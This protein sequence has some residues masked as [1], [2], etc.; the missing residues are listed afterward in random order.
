VQLFKPSSLD[1]IFRFARGNNHLS[2]KDSCEIYLAF[3][4]SIL[5]SPS[6]FI[7]QRNTLVIFQLKSDL[8]NE[9]F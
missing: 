3:T 6:A 9:K 4:R 2:T 7:K 8:V 1:T 5:Y